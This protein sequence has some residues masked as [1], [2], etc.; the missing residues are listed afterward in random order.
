MLSASLHERGRSAAESCWLVATVPGTQQ[1]PKPC[2]MNRRWVAAWVPGFAHLASAGVLKL[3]TERLPC[4]VDRSRAFLVQGER[5]HS[6][7][8][9]LPKDKEDGPPPDPPPPPA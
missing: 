6:I 1:V 3:L 9:K 2:W 4:G 5:P 7:Q 8:E